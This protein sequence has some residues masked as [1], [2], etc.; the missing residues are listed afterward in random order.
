MNSM[1]S[2]ANIE[3][4]SVALQ[5]MVY[6]TLAHDR[7]L[8]MMVKRQVFDGEAGA[9][10]TL[11]YVVMGEIEEQPADLLTQLGRQ[12]SLTIHVFS[13][14]KGNKEASAI[15][16]RIIQL[17]NQTALPVGPNW[18]IALAQF[19]SCQVVPDPGEAR[20]Y[21]IRM[22]YRMHARSRF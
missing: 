21:V 13:N 15:A 5:P 10:A 8:T 11:P 18:Y 19:K 6:S 4:A 16:G 7:M 2:I 14:Y 1:A 9:N 12:V 22:E 3:P 20:H 17:L